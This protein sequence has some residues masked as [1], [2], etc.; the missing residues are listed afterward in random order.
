MLRVRA[1][2]L[3]ELRNEDLERLKRRLVL[4]D[5]SLLM[6]LGEGVNVLEQLMDF[7]AICLIPMSVLEELKK[8]ASQGRPRG[9][10]AK[11]ALRIIENECVLLKERLAKHTDDDIVALALKYGL[12]V[13]TADVELRRRVLRKVPTLYFRKSQRRVFSEDFFPY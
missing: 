5:T 4:V 12:A 3:K 8:L 9:R 11:L 13:A 6:L 10:K 7:G 2:P 1:Q